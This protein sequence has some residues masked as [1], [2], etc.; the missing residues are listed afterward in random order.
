MT[1]TY[2]YAADVFPHALGHKFTQAFRNGFFTFVT[3]NNYILNFKKLKGN[4]Y[5]NKQNEQS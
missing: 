4:Y 1:V 3:A 5:I 2:Y